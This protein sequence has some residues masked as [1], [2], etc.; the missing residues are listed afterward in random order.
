MKKYVG[1]IVGTLVV[2]G[3]AIYLFL[4]QSGSNSQPIMANNPTGGTTGGNTT[5]TGSTSSTSG[6]MGGMQMGNYKD[7]TYTGPVTDAVYGQLEVVVTI[8]NGMITDTN[9]PIYPNDP[10][11][12]QEVNSAALPQLR[13]E[14]IAAQNANINIVSGATQ[15]SQAYQQS[16][17][18]ALAQAQA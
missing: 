5:G 15:T 17:A 7:G 2:A 8:K 14:A 10:G 1:Y 16:L 18:A 6:N 3:V 13:Q 12:T 4:S 9:C 11:H